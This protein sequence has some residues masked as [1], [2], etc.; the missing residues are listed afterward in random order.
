MGG[1]GKGGSSSSTT[2]QKVEPWSGQKPYLYDIYGTAQHL[3]QNGSFAPE[4]YPGNTVAPMDDATK[5][6]LALQEER[7]LGGNAG[8][9][10]AQNQLAQTMSGDYLNKNPFMQSEG[11]PELDAMV[12]RAIGQANA[13][14]AGNYASAGRYGSGA[15]NAAA[16]D[17]AGNIASS[18]YGQAYDN[19]QNRK[20]SAWNNERNNQ[21]K[22]M[23]FAPQLAAADYQDLAALSEVGTARE[24]SAQELIN[25]D[26]D[27][28]NYDANQP[29]S[30]LQGYA[31]LIYG[32][33]SP[34]MS[35]SSSS[36]GGRN[37]PLGGALSGGLAGGGLGYLL[38]QGST[39]G[40]IGAGLGGLLGLF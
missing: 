10:A 35:G 8:M 26:V 16:N 18:M 3:F 6:A 36:S 39:G 21:I 38:G 24:N 20:L 11:N 32:S 4:Y 28:Y 34:G 22:G 7:A 5:Q 31:N 29:A 14:T 1:G 13:G 19:D 37:N 17:A 9:T 33:G 15:F 25:A 12:Q 23:M 27:K 30:N 2:T 40:L